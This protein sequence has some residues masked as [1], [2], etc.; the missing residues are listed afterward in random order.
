MHLISGLSQVDWIRQVRC[1]YK[2]TCEQNGCHGICGCH[3]CLQVHHF[4]PNYHLKTNKTSKA[5]ENV[6]TSFT[7]RFIQNKLFYWGRLTSQQ[8]LK[9]HWDLPSWKMWD[10]NTLK[11]VVFSMYFTGET[12]KVDHDLC[13]HPRGH[14]LYRIYRNRARL[15]YCR[16][17]CAQTCGPASVKHS[18]GGH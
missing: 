5:Q 12:L 7:W 16:A 8:E 15:I 17:V 9:T 3:G 2:N 10:L 18:E 11:P 1:D 4:H 6:F 13:P 14:M